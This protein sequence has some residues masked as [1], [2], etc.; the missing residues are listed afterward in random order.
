M[1]LVIILLFTFTTRV[2]ILSVA[3]L[4]L[5][6]SL[7]V[8]LSLC[9]SAC[10]ALTCESIDLQNSYLVYRYLFRISAT[11]AYEGHRVKVKVKTWPC[12][13]PVRG[14]SFFRLKGNLVS[15]YFYRPHGGITLSSRRYLNS[16]KKDKTITFPT[17]SKPWNDLK[18]ASVPRT[19]TAA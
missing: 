3:Y 16:M 8:S 18:N 5:C 13:H 10:N 17:K 11:F 14:W 12:I 15:N 9:L 2:V 7:C 4:S 19:K 6:L 1:H